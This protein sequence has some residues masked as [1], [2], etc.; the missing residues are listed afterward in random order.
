MA[1]NRALETSYDVEGNN[2]NDKTSKNN[3]F[4]VISDSKVTEIPFLDKCF[5]ISILV[6]KEQKLQ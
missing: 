6:F 5:V 3:V 2:K 1:T 4:W